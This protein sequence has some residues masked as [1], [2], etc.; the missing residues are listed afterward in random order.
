MQI[1]VLDDDPLVLSS[2]QRWLRSR[3]TD[4]VLARDNASAMGALETAAR[5]GAPF[6]LVILDRQLEGEQGTDLLPW[7]KRLHPEAII[8]VVSAFLDARTGVE[9]ASD[10]DFIVNKP[11]DEDAFSLMIEKVSAARSRR[12]DPLVSYYEAANLSPRERD[13]AE[14][15]LRGQSPKEIAAELGITEGTVYTLLHRIRDKTGLSSQLEL[16]AELARRRARRA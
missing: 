11:V 13:V 4:A 2:F 16:V 7:I 10:C 12:S 9:L 15:T 5:E 1:L 3:D 8:A 14:G 6:D